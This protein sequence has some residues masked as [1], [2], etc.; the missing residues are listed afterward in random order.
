MLLRTTAE[1]PDDADKSKIIWTSDNENVVKVSSNGILKA[2]GCGNATI[3]AKSTDDTS[4][5]VTAN[6][7]VKAKKAK[8]AVCKKKNDR[9]VKVRAK[10]QNG[11][12]SF[13]YQMSKTSNFKPGRTSSYIDNTNSDVYTARLSAKKTYYFRTR[14]IYYA[15][16][17]KCYGPWSNTVKIKTG[18][19]GNT[20]WNCIWKNPK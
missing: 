2:V 9:W 7:T 3:T 5:T 17:K 15:N 20:S 14:A 19:K 10:S 6:I 12:S 4:I 8:F 1:Q 16:G 18:T 13:Q 11:V